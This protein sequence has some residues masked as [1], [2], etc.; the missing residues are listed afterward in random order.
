MAASET[1]ER[2]PN[3]AMTKLG[4]MLGISST[5]QSSRTESN[6]ASSSS[7]ASLSSIP[8][9]PTLQGKPPS[10]DLTSKDLRLHSSSNSSLANASVTT[11]GNRK[12]KS[13]G[14]SSSNVTGHVAPINLNSS[15]IPNLSRSGSVISKAAPVARFVMRE[16]GTHE[17]QFRNTKR[18]EKLG[19]MVKDWLGAKKLRNS[20]VSAIPNILSSTNLAALDNEAKARMD[21]ASNKDLPPTLLSGLLNQV[22]RGDI[23]QFSG[24]QNSI[25]QP[26]TAISVNMKPEEADNRLFV[27]K[28]GECQE[29]IG[30]GAFGVVRVAHK[31][32][33]GPGP[34]GANEILFAVKEFRR[35]PNESD[36]RYSKR[37]TSEFCISSSLKH[38]N[39]ISTVDLLKDAKSDY[40]EVME[41]CSGGDLYS[42]IVTAG[43]LEYAEADCFF[44]QLTRGLNYMHKMGVAHRDLKPE[45]LLLTARG[46]LKIT[47]FG[48]AECFKMAWEDEIQYSRGICG[49]SPYI[50]PEE[51]TQK[52]FDP[53][54]IDVWACGVIYMAMRTGRQ[55]WK[56]ANIEDEFFTT[57]LQKRKD[58]KGYEP[59]EGLKRARCRNVIYSIL[60]PVPQRRITCAQ[61]LN[62]EWVREIK[63][64]KAGDCGKRPE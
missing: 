16:D 53:R 10:S 30:R 50:A 63:I 24:P 15:D 6:S 44:K 54:P 46:T 51:Y 23:T 8:S 52:E 26:T 22:K 5:K 14:Q 31:K 27:E 11:A 58:A 49:S 41:Y 19:Q 43:K 33:A 59:I 56:L 20:A 38:L 25:Q 39:I 21:A 47:D 57:Y 12:V 4:K 64:C 34:D 3:S 36:S 17:H 37:L 45:N 32:L 1:A 61:I 48:N 18:Q 29:V 13:P 60:D 40:C 62:S 28:Y 2:H 9:S 7:N 55:L 35:R 42:L